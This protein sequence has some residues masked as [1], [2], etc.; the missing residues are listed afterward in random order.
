MLKRSNQLLAKIARHRTLLPPTIA[1]QRV[2]A[3]D[4]LEAVPAQRVQKAILP[5]SSLANVAAPS[6]AP[7]IT[8]SAEGDAPIALKNNGR[9][10][11]AIPCPRSESRLARHMPATL[12]LNQVARESAASS[13]RAV[14]AGRR[15]ILG[16]LRSGA[17]ARE[18]QALKID[19]PH[20][21]AI[22]RACRRPIFGDQPD[23][24]HA[25]PMSSG[26]GGQHR[27]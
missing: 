2:V 24:R 5:P 8:P 9:I 21:A 14:G 7:S 6:D 12:R 4:R 27:A 19:R 22:P 10:A 13:F 15:S 11:V 25:R 1:A 20:V 3:I 26:P 17:A 16:C 23:A 18:R